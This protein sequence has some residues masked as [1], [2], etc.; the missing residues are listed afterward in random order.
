M[1]IGLGVLMMLAAAPSTD[2]WA[3][4]DQAFV[5][6]ETL[7]DDAARAQAVKRFM[8]QASAAD[9]SRSVFS[10]MIYRRFLLEKHECRQTLANL[11]AY[12]AAIEAGAVSDQDWLPIGGRPGVL[13]SISVVGTRPYADPR[14]PDDRAVETYVQ[15]RLAQPAET[16]LTHTRYDELVSHEVFYCGSNQHALIEND[17]FLAGASALK[18]P[19]PS[20]RYGAVRVYA[21]EPTESGTTNALIARTACSALPTELT[22]EGGGRGADD[23]RG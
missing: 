5:C 15:V 14:R 21:P 3:A 22:L 23:Q 4:V 17:Y 9:P 8:N 18:D 6:P 2:A 16:D 20:A 10:L 13:I 19:S 11:H 1:I 7:A 12:Q